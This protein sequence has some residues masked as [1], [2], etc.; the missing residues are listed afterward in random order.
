MAPAGVATALMAAG[1]LLWQ[2]GA[3]RLGLPVTRLRLVGEV[4]LGIGCYALALRLLFPVLFGD[5]RRFIA[6]RK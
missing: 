5:A 4:L 1:L 6:R 2:V 3:G